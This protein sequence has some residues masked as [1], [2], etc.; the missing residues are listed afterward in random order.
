MMNSY[1][2]IK[3]IDGVCMAEIK[4]EP[5]HEWLIKRVDEYLDAIHEARKSGNI[6]EYAETLSV[7]VSELQW[8]FD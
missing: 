5:R 7:L 1:E 4:L 8:S 2:F 6:R 3:K